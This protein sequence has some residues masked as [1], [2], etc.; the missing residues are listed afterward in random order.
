MDLALRKLS[1][2]A[3]DDSLRIA[4]LVQGRVGTPCTVDYRDDSRSHVRGAV[5]ESQRNLVNLGTSRIITS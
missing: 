5:Y 4:T 2:R 3:T 1:P